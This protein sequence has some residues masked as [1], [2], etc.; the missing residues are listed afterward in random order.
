[1]CGITG[2]IDCIENIETLKKSIPKMTESLRHRGPNAQA[3]R[4]I[5][6]DNTSI[7]LGHTRLSIL[8][9]SDKAN[10]P[11]VSK[12]GNTIIIHNG[13]VYNFA[14]IKIT[15]EQKGYQFMTNS[16]TEVILYAYREWGPSC[17]NH[18]RGMFAFAILDIKHKKLLLFRDRAGV[19]PLYIYQKNSVILFG[20]ELKAFHQNPK[21]SAELDYNVLGLYLKHGDICAPHCIFKDTYKIKPG[22]YCSIDLTTKKTS[23]HSYWDAFDYYNKPIL[24]ISFSAFSL[25]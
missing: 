21:F 16:D 23:H 7:A 9:L 3:H 8:D 24:D 14:E 19:K 11:M 18:F 6:I 5:S 1:M 2:I 17:V 4:V 15:L 12:D 10:Q 22:H 25:I 20:S 13:E